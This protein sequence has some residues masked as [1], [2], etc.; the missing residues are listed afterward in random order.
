MK[1]YRLKQIFKEYAESEY[2][3]N[4]CRIKKRFLQM[5]SKVFSEN[6]KIKR[7]EKSLEK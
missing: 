7:N 6:M 5:F 2:S 4:P 3:K 1:Q